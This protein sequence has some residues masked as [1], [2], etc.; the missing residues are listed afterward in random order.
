M[1]TAVLEHCPLSEAQDLNCGDVARA[2]RSGFE[3]TLVAR[4]GWRKVSNGAMGNQ[5]AAFDIANAAR[6]YAALAM[7]I[8][9]FRQR[10][11]RGES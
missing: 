6:G 5:C 2:R 4:L 11:S 1:T 10:A 3:A 7:C 9:S 8:P